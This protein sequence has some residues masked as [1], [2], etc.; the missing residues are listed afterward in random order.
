MNIRITD[1]RKFW[2][3]AFGRHVNSTGELLVNLTLA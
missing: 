2:K 3:K 1:E